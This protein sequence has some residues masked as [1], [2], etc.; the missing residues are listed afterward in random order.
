MPSPANYR[1]D[2]PQQRPLTARE[3]AVVSAGNARAD[4]AAYQAMIPALNL[5]YAE[6]AA[7]RAEEAHPGSL[8]FGFLARG[9]RFAYPCEGCTDT[10]TFV[11]VSGSRVRR[12]SDG[13]ESS[14]P[15][16]HWPVFLL[17]DEA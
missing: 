6:Y 16:S 14:A 10:D 7:R 12:E 9:E 15:Y 11:K 17:A 2:D 1:S 8:P 5:S 4:F 13:K 3:F